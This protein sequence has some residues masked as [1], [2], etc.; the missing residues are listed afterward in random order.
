MT[1]QQKDAE[2][3]REYEESSLQQETNQDLLNFRESSESTRRGR[4]ALSRHSSSRSFILENDYVEKLVYQRSPLSGHWKQLFNVYNTV[5]Q[6]SERNPRFFSVIK[7][8]ATNLGKKQRCLLIKAIQL[9]NAKNLGILRLI[10][11]Y[12]K[13]SMQIPSKLG[14]R[15]SIG[16]RVHFNIENWTEPDGEPTEFEWKL[17]PRIHTVCRFSPRSRNMMI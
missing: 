3:G 2:K 5:D 10:I 1:H 8:A 15:R 17:F 9:S 14:R 6:G 13:G 12:G 7:W 11:V 4:G 16:F